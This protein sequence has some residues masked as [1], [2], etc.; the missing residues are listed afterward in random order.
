M[1]RILSPNYN[2]RPPGVPID[3]IVLHYTGMSTAE[4]ALNRMV[5]S[6][7][8]VSAHYLIHENGEVI[9]L[10]EEE[11]RTWHA[12]KSS[13][14]GRENVNDVS[15]GIELVNPGHEFG[16]RAF[17][18]PQ[19][20][21]LAVLC[22]DMMARH[23]IEARNVVGHADIAPERKEDPG[24]LFDWAWMAS[25]G[26]GVFPSLNLSDEYPVTLFEQG[27]EGGDVHQMQEGLM[28]YGYMIQPNGLFDEHTAKV[29]VAFR[30]H[31]APQ[32]IAPIWDNQAQAMLDALLRVPDGL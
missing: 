18:E 3:T 9:Q 22:Q 32:T 20:Q 4:A 30:R 25:Q 12:G 5:D 17:P 10:V 8:E 6:A 26:I 19:M 23:P 21:A 7:S 11:H 28:R 16:Y 31:F 1:Q 2:T 27:A 29:V 14:R 15:I 13:W 24:E